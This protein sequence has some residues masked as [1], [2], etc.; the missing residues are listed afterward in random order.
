MP[1]STEAQQRNCITSQE[2]DALADDL[3]TGIPANITTVLL[4]MRV[5]ACWTMW[6]IL[7][8]RPDIKA[9]TALDPATYVAGSGAYPGIER[10]EAQLATDYTRRRKRRD[11]ETVSLEHPVLALCRMIARGEADPC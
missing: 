9:L 10:W 6:A 5:T 1:W 8:T 7:K 3:R 2:L 11:G 4:D